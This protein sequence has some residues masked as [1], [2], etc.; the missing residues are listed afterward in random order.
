MYG[1]SNLR[2]ISTEILKPGGTKRV[3]SE[4]VDTMR[5]VTEKLA[6]LALVDNTEP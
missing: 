6:S 5:E 1:F 4:N 3:A 2:R